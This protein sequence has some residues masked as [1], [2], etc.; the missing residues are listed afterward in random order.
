MSRARYPQTWLPDKQRHLENIARS[1]QDT[2]DAFRVRGALI[3]ADVFQ[4]ITAAPGLPERIVWGGASKT[5]IWDTI[6]T[7]EY[8]LN[9]VWDDAQNEWVIPADVTHVRCSLYARI[10]NQLGAPGENFLSIRGDGV[11][12]TTQDLAADRRSVA[13]AANLPIVT[14]TTP[15]FPVT[16]GDT[17]YAMCGNDAWTGAGATLQAE[18]RFQIEF[19]EI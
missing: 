1:A 5:V 12:T 15:I 8:D 19:V 16:P 4:Y 14:I 7:P 17:I 9:T 13:S 10:S 3:E 6:S 18:R 2:V 11:F